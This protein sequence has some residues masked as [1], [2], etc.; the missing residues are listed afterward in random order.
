MPFKSKRQVSI[1]RRRSKTGK[2][3][4]HLD[5]AKQ[6]FPIENAFL[7]YRKSS[8]AGIGVFAKREIS[9][10]ERITE[11]KRIILKTEREMLSR[12]RYYK[13]VKHRDTVYFL[14]LKDNRGYVDIMQY[15]NEGR[16][17]TQSNEPN[18]FAEHH[19]TL[20]KIII[21]ALRDIPVDTELS[22]DYCR[23]L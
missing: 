7:E 11:Y 23:L 13:R 3:I 22:L 19:E 10:G 4:S 17:I 18:C 6:K 21:Y 20:N 15:K 1:D 16:F 8:T 9:K 5:I 2:L 12:S 14:A